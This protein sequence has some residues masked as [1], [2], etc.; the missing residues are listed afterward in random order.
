MGDAQSRKC[1]RPG[2]RQ[3][4]NVFVFLASFP[5]SWVKARELSVMNSHKNIPV[6]NQRRDRRSEERLTTAYRAPGI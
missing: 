1:A 3:K 2:L 5:M 4:L 6:S